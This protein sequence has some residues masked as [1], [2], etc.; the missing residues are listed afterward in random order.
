MNLIHIVMT[1]KIMHSCRMLKAR[2]NQVLEAFVYCVAS[3]A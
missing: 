2:E 1:N 3:I